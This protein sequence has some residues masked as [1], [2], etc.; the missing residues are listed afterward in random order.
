[1][2]S[3]GY[4]N[5]LSENCCK[6]LLDLFSA[7]ENTSFARRHTYHPD[8]NESFWT[9]EPFLTPLEQVIL[10]VVLFVI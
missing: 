8:S 6:I 2:L 3:D 1:M 7:N 10:L 9:R 5:A 4:G